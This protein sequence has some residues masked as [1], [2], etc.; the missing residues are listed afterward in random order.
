MASSNLNRLFIGSILVLVVL[1][2]YINNFDLLFIFIL[3][4]FISYDLFHIKVTSNYFLIF[5]FASS[6]LAMSL[7][8]FHLFE[9]LFIFQSIIVLCI[10]FLNKYKRELFILSL[11]IFCIIIF[12][13]IN[14]D[15]NLFYMLIFISFFNDTVAYIFGKYLKGPLI[16]PK[17]SPK[18]TWSGTSISFISTTLLLLFF[19]FDIFISMLIS[20]FLFIGDI[21]FSY[22][23]RHL[24][25][26]DFSS[27]L[28]SH[29]GIL[30]RLDS[31]FF[32]AIIFQIYLFYSV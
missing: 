6:I 5:F 4:S 10:F 15:R 23:K 29:G 17:I 1:L 12:Y 27:L 3:L 14:I 26:K 20:S 8:S 11:Y 25:I 22:I 18:K 28:G 30:D 31:M 2:F 21:F 24:N 32:V 7:I 13:I 16:L 9:N 19:D